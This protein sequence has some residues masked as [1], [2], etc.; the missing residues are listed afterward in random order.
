MVD[1]L[2]RLVEKTFKL[3]EKTLYELEKNVLLNFTV[4]LLERGEKLA[5]LEERLLDLKGETFLEFKQENSFELEK[6][7]ELDRE[8]LLSLDDE[9]IRADKE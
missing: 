4:K 3:D 9:L 2:L 6:L 5:R 7:I 1:T 8:T